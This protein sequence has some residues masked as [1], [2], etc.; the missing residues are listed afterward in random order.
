[1]LTFFGTGRIE[2]TW[3]QCICCIGTFDGVHLGHQEVIKTARLIADNVG[4]PLVVITFDRHPAAT[5]RPDLKPPSIQ[6]LTENLRTFESCGAD[7]CLVL[8]FDENLAKTTAEDFYND[9]ISKLLMATHVVIGGDFG[10]GAGR[11][12]PGEW[13]SQHV[14]TTV[15]SPFCVDGIRVSSTVVRE[16]IRSGDIEAANRYL[17]RPFCI[18]GVVVRGKQIGRTLGFP[19]ANLALAED[20]AVPADGV[21]AG[22]LKLGE[23]V[24]GAAISVGTNPTLGDNARTIE[25]FLLDYDGPEFYGRAVRLEFVG[26][27][28][29]MESFA[30]LE[31]LREQMVHD[32]EQI[33]TIL[34]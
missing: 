22:H 16:A 17:G 33:R 23:K 20:L 28:R 24:Y 3:S 29:T 27:I 26:Q 32:V 34:T 19:T 5:L 8:S 2:P 4:L 21:Y 11:R 18:S 6:G 9:V 25:A 10:F 15:V 7:V 31:S 30:N 13:I 14:A 12:G 1:M